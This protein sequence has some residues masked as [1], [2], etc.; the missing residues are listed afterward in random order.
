[1]NRETIVAAIA[2]IV[3]SGTAWAQ[4]DLTGFWERKDLA[5]SGSFGG[6]DAKIPK[7]VLFLVHRRR[8]RKLPRIPRRPVRANRESLTL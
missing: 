7:A 1:M 6:L 5:G 3:L 2:M 8:R 4:R